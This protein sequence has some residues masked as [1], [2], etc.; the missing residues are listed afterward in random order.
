MDGVD[1][2]RAAAE[3]P[4]R[5]ATGTS[6]DVD[7]G[8]VVTGVAMATHWAVP[9][10]VGARLV[11]GPSR[12]RFVA[13]RPVPSVLLLFLAD[14]TL[15]VVLGRVDPESLEFLRDSEPWSQ[16]VGDAEEEVQIV[17]PE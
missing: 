12:L 15:G 1:D 4:E 7:R 8:T 13:L 16:L 17:L 9:G 10:L 5:A 14:A 6:P 11:A 2:V 3:G